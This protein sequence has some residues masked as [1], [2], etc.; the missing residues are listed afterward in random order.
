VGDLSDRAKP[1]LA[2]NLC[3]VELANPTILA[4]GI[5]GTCTAVLRRVAR[6]GA[7]AVTI[8][9][10]GL[11]PRSGHNNP[12]VIAFE[13]GLMNA[14][15][16][17]NPGAEAALEQFADIGDVG[18]PVIGSVIGTRP[19]DFARVI[20]IIGGLP[21]A[22]FE[23]PL[24]CPHTP[25]FG[26]LAGQG[27][28][29]ATEAITKAVR[30]A[31]DK[32]VIVKVSPSVSRL[33]EVARAAEAAGADAV[34]AVNSLGPGMLV[35]IETRQPIL[36][37]KVGGVTGPAL[38]PIALRCVY[39]IFEAVKIPI[40]G[41]GGISTGRHALEMIMVGAA[42]VGIGSGVYYEGIGVFKKVCRE[43]REWMA[44]NGVSSLSEIVG[45]A[46]D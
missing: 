22:A 12:T 40:I 32:P 11:A 25:G 13:A 21:F 26:L 38:R 1:S 39:D 5:L 17:S 14:V 41:V 6:N 31:T 23:L 20:D 28:P 37:F 43:M 34:C 3:G 9:S 30:R 33:G 8:K 27:T 18:V 15:G 10:I 29:E 36:D 2:V 42:A 24:S 44:E 46:H 35:D 19:D 16:Y 45:V 4:S 7:G